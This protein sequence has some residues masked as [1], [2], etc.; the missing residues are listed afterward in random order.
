MTIG[1]YHLSV[2]VDEV[3]KLLNP[4][5]G[6]VFVDVT[7]GDGGHAREILRASKPDG[8]LIGIDRDPEAIAASTVRLADMGNRVRL[9]SG[10]MGDIA[11]I[12]RDI[13]IEIV[14]G[15]FADLGVSSRHLDMAN[16]GFSF[17]NDAPLDMR[18]N[19]ES[20]K[21]A[22]EFLA[23]LDEH[24]IENLLRDFG[25]ERYARRIANAISNSSYIETT[26]EL[27]RI[28]TDA[29]PPFARH[30]RIHPAT[31]TFQAIR[32]AVNDEMG[33][34]A[35]FLEAA[36]NLLGPGGR[37]VVISYHSLEDRMVK[38]ALRA[39]AIGGAFNLP[40]RK[41]LKPGDDEISNNPRSRSAKL[42]VLER[43]A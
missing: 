32:I 27:S 23:G 15:I 8:M 41:V 13:G 17:R 42:R 26:A 25:E 1:N 19:P 14:D 33:E 34:L 29:V 43:A 2:M 30:S 36:P 4:K 9:V 38:K 37:M 40:R 28:V 21:S 22:A 24:E 11:N 16:R 7:L 10:R 39:L 18:M 20:G 12:F 5:P 35:R 3:V 31:R 6:S